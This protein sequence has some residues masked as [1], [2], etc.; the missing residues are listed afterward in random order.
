MDR[1]PV[2]GYFACLC[3][4]VTGLHVFAFDSF[5]FP[6]LASMG[7]G[8]VWILGLTGLKIADMLYLPYD[9]SA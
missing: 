5:E 4:S 1:L 3:L 9:H 2:F 8:G 7:F 6:T